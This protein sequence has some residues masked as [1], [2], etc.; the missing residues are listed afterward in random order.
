MYYKQITE[1][2][3]DKKRFEIYKQVGLEKKEI[4]HTIRTQVL[5]VFFLP[6]VT[7]GMHIIF[8]FPMIKRLLSLFNMTNTLLFMATTS[9]CF[10]LFSVV[11]V[12]VYVLSAK[13][14][15]EIVD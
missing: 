10:L 4:Q 7:A 15:Y 13:T 9:I 14:Y 8:A 3:E 12:L 2:N 1:G 6:L 11:Y 5:M